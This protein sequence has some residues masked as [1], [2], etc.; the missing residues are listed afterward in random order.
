MFL[1]ILSG[2]DIPELS[3]V[4]VLNLSEVIT[5]PVELRTLAI[6]GLK[7]GE[8]QIQTHLRN[9]SDIREAVHAVLK[10]WHKSQTNSKV[11]YLKLCHALKESKMQ[12]YVNHILNK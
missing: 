7:K 12:Y 10:D 8:Y 11:A 1:L 2:D 4:K 6:R 3:D 5:G 9:K